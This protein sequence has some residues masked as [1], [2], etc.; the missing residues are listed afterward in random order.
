MASV[1]QEARRSGVLGGSNRIA[2][3]DV[4]PNNNNVVDVVVDD[5]GPPSFA[6]SK[7]FQDTATK[8]VRILLN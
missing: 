8:Q 2:A 6:P 5:I 7:R 3:V 1:E 4:S